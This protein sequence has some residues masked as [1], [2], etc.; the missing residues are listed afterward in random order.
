[1]RQN[2]INKKKLNFPPMRVQAP[3]VHEKKTAYYELKKDGTIHFE[4][5][6]MNK[7][8][9]ITPTIPPVMN[10]VKEQ[11]HL[12]QSKRAMDKDFVQRRGL[13]LTEQLEKRREQLAQHQESTQ[14]NSI[15]KRLFN[16]WKR[17][18]EE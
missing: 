3:Q 17:E 4:Y 15:W 16:R 12:Y 11:Q 7:R 6:K 10:G 8:E 1:M 14:S 2:Q 18:E 5:Q 9:Q 13:I